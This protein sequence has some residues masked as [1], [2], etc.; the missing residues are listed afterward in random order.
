MLTPGPHN[1]LNSK[2]WDSL[3]LSKPCEG[4]ICSL[5]RARSHWV[6]NRAGKEMDYE[7]SVIIV[8]C[9]I[10]TVKGTPLHPDV[11]QPVLNHL[12][13]IVSCAPVRAFNVDD[14]QGI[15]QDSAAE[16]LHSTL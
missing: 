3:S 10:S 8:I 13:N 14:H 7:S 12:H 9:V 15:C 6:T 4:R 1:S 5:C 16:I 11:L 2:T